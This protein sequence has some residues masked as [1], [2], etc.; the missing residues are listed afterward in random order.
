M[1]LTTTQLRAAWAPACKLQHPRTITLNG[2]GRVTV[3]GRVVDAV[4]ALNDVLK[5]YS[6][7]TR[8]GDTGA[9]NCRKITGG[10]GYSLHAYGTAIDINWGTNPYGRRLITDMPPAMVDEILAIRTRNGKQVWRWGGHYTTNRDAMHYEIVCTPADLATGVVDAHAG[11]PPLTDDQKALVFIA[12]QKKAA[13][14]P[15]H[16]QG[17]RR[18]PHRRAVAKLQQLLGM[19]RTGVYGTATRAKVKGVQTFFGLPVTGIVDA[20][21]WTWIIY[22]ALVKGR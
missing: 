4:L 14:L 12:A 5:Q 6:Y 2:D 10:T 22:A 9:Y 19:T 21:T 11:P 18:H 20:D 3:D 13:A 15:V 8:R 1:T 16:G 17:H 7:R